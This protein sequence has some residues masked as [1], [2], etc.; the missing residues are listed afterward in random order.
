MIGPRTME[1]GASDDG[2]R[3]LG[4]WNKGLRMMGARV[5]GG[6]NTDWSHS[7]TRTFRSFRFFELPTQADA[8]TGCA[9]RPCFLSDH[10]TYSCSATSGNDSCS[11]L[12]FMAHASSI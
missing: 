10:F 7:T 12:D 1:Q 5:L 3:G 8:G 6:A 2:T 9:E 4:R 11:T